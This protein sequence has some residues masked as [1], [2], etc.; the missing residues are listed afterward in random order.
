MAFKAFAVALAMLASQ[1]AMSAAPSDDAFRRVFFNARLALREERNSDAVKLWLLN[2]SLS[3]DKQQASAY[4]ADFRSVLWA[5]YERMGWCPD[6]LLSDDE[7]GAGIWPLAA[8]NILLRNL[9]MRR[10]DKKAPIE[11]LDWFKKGEQ[12]RPIAVTDFLSARELK[13]VKFSPRPCETFEKMKRTYGAAGA[14]RTKFAHE[15]LYYLYLAQK[16]ID[17]DKIVSF[18]PIEARVLDTLLYFLDQGERSPTAGSY[19][20]DANRLLTDA[21][22]WAPDEWYDLQSERRTFLFSRASD[23]MEDAHRTEVILF[24]IDALIADKKGDELKKWIAFLE[25]AESPKLRELVWQGERG[26]R[27]LLLTPEDGFTERGVVAWH[28]GIDFLSRGNLRESLRSL[29]LAIRYGDESSEVEAIRMGA[30]RWI[31]YIAGY[32]EV[33]DTLMATLKEVLPYEDFSAVLQDLLWRSILRFDSK[34]FD[35]LQQYV[36][37]RSAAAARF[38]QF[39]TMAKGKLTQFFAGIRKL[40]REEPTLAGR[41]LR[42]YL[43][44][45]EKEDA[46][47]RLSHRTLLGELQL[48][49]TRL[50]KEQD[51]RGRRKN[52]FVL[53]LLV[54]IDGILRGLPHRA[55][56]SRDEAIRAL[57][58]NATIFAG[59]VRVPP[60]DAV[61]WPF[62]T[63]DLRA[64]SI[65]QPFRI[66]PVE[67][68][69]AKN[70]IVFGWRVRE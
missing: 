29:G 10:F 21:S 68:R 7:G 49:L 50:S 38:E 62:V 44:E 23:H 36:N 54:R 43:D 32:Y 8:A 70:D 15:L 52:R 40:F 51:T 19:E 66:E 22:N 6:G 9:T 58:P 63:G 64:P 11:G 48:E 65:F 14:N 3:L 27:L 61:P 56:R 12:S 2:H 31:S 30:R 18:A 35:K 25:A 45:L 13:T 28:R 47:V 57:N 1:S 33:N 59:N 39:D 46:S 20:A 24:M 5:S 17:E 4:Q 37:T 26:K 16:H 55:E 42:T 41:Y 60:K 34:S 69:D 53:E 67:W